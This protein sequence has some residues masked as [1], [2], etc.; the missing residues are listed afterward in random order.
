VA[1]I[2]LTMAKHQANL[3]LRRQSVLECRNSN[4]TVKQWCAEH[5]INPSTFYRWQ[6]EVWNHETQS[7]ISER[8]VAAAEPIRFAEIS[9]PDVMKTASSEADIVLRKDE[10]TVEIR[11]SVDAALLS[12][13]LRVVGYRG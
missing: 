2:S 12:Q 7:L 5:H 10:W 6:K 13:I 9:V 1:N 11:N 8:Q 4:L 3:E